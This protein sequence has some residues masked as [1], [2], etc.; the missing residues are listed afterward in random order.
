MPLRA[1]AISKRQPRP[2]DLRPN[3]HA[4][5]YGRDWKII[6]DE[7]L[8]NYPWC[9]LCGET[10]TDVDHIRP[11]KQG[12]TDDPDNLQT[13]CHKHHSAKTARVDGGFGNTR[14]TR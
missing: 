4:R 9:V 5:G 13:L 10:G 11:R 14:R 1:R 12:G 6:R 2:P 8:R 3:A 7:H